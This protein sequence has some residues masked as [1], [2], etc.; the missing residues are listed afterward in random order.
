MLRYPASESQ[1]LVKN[2]YGGE[3]KKPLI[4]PKVIIPNL[5]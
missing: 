2:S 4:H 1:A 5:N 3:S